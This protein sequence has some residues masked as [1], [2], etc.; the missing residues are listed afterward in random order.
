MTQKY[1]VGE[2]DQ[3]HLATT[4][5]IVIIFF[6]GKCNEACNFLTHED[7]QFLIFFFLKEL[8]SQFRRNEH[9]L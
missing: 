2:F 4:S 3:K 7:E 5:L 8:L 6:S 9:S 1:R